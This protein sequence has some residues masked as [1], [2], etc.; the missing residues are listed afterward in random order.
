LIT[1]LVL[2][3]VLVL[4]GGGGIAAFLVLKDA[5]GEGQPSAVQAAEK[6]LTAVY[7]DKDAAAASK[8]VC[9]SA[10]DERKLNDKIDELRRYEDKFDRD[11]RFAWEQPK[12]DS[13]GKDTAKLSVT[14]KFSTNDDRG[15]EQKL[16]ITAV[17]DDGWFVCDV[18]SVG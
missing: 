7:V 3:A 13:T 17:D 10:R 18:Q 11:P 12:V 14:V 16:A 2:V 5:G 9:S 1:V 8:Y 4:C 15:A 6:F